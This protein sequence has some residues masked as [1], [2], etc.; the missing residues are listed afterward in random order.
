MQKHFNDLL[1][2]TA[3]EGASERIGVS[4]INQQDELDQLMD[5]WYRERQE[6]VEAEMFLERAH[7]LLRRIIS[8]G[9]MTSANGRKARHL[10]L[11]IKA[12][13]QDDSG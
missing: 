11:A 9:R 5:A 4:P 7:H 10:L 3:N 8:E 2:K 12:I 1:L 13:S 6:R